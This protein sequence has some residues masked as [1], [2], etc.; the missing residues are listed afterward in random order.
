MNYALQFL[1]I[2]AA[3]ALL[4]FLDLRFAFSDFLNPD[5]LVEVEKPWRPISRAVFGVVTVPMILVFAGWFSV[6]LYRDRSG[7]RSS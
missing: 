6:A 2:A 4:V 5:P 3:T 7:R 1:A